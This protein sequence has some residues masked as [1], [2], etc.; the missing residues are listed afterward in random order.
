MRPNKGEKS[1]LLVLCA[2]LFRFNLQINL[3]F[4]FYLKMDNNMH[5][6]Y[7]L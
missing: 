1:I 2:H 5:F 6:Y 4:Y 7:I 3:C